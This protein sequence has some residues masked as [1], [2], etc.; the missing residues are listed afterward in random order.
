MSLTLERFN[1]IRQLGASNIASSPMSQFRTLT[2]NQGNEQPIDGMAAAPISGFTSQT[3]R[4][5]LSPEQLRSQQLQA[6]RKAGNEP[7]ARALERQEQMQSGGSIRDIF[8]RAGMQMDTYNIEQDILDAGGIFGDTE[9]AK[10]LT[11]IRDRV[12]QIQSDTLKDDTSGVFGDVAGSV[13][14][15]VQTVKDSILPTIGGAVVG[16]LVGGPA[17]A[18]LGAKIAFGGSSLLNWA[19]QGGG[20]IYADNIKDGIAPE[21]ARIVALAGG[22]I[23]GGIE[24]IFSVVSRFQPAL[25]QPIRNYLTKNL[26]SSILKAVSR[27]GFNVAGEVTEEGLQ[28]GVM[29]VAYNVAA[30]MQEN[31]AANGSPLTPFASA[32]IMGSMLE[33]MKESVLPIMILG[34]V[35]G[36]VDLQRARNTNTRIKDL[37]SQYKKIIPA[38]NDQEFQRI[39]EQAA[40]ERMNIP[41]A[42]RPMTVD[43]YINKLNQNMSQVRQQELINARAEAQKATEQIAIKQEGYRSAYR[44]FIDNPNASSQDVIN[45][46]DAAAASMDVKPKL[47]E[48]GSVNT[49]AWRVA[50]E[51]V[52]GEDT[53][54]VD[55]VKARVLSEI[56]DAYNQRLDQEAQ[57]INPAKAEEIKKNKALQ[58]I[59]R[60]EVIQDYNNR[61][62]G[63]AIIKEKDLIQQLKAP[64]TK[65]QLIEQIRSQYETEEG[66]AAP[67]ATPQAAPQAQGQVTPPQEPPEAGGAA[68]PVTPP[69]TPIE[70]TRVTR[71]EQQ[72]DGTEAEVVYEKVTAKSGTQGWRKIDAQTGARVGPFLTSGKKV[73]ELEILAR[74]QELPKPPPPPPPAPPMTQEQAG[75]ITEDL[76]QRQAAEQ[77]PTGVTDRLGATAQQELN[78]LNRRE[79][80]LRKVNLDDMTDAQMQELE[81]IEARKEEILGPATATVEERRILEEMGREPEE[82]KPPEKPESEFERIAREARERKIAEGEGKAAVRKVEE[83]RKREQELKAQAR[84]DNEERRNSLIERMRDPTN[85]LELRDVLPVEE[86]QLIVQGTLKKTDKKT[87]REYDEFVGEYIYTTKNGRTAWY[88]YDSTKN[89]DVPLG[90]KLGGEATDP[91]LIASLEARKTE[92]QSADLAGRRVEVSLKEVADKLG[93]SENKAKALLSAAGYSVGRNIKGVGR[94]VHK[95]GSL[96]QGKAA[97]NRA[98]IEAAQPEVN[99]VES[100]T[101]SITRA[102]NQAPTEA[103]SA[104]DDEMNAIAD[105]LRNPTITKERRAELTARGKELL[106]IRRNQGGREVGGRGQTEDADDFEAQQ[107]RYQTASVTNNQPATR[108]NVGAWV[109]GVAQKIV[110]SRWTEDRTSSDTIGHLRIGTKSIRFVIGDAGMTPEGQRAAGYVQ[111][112]TVG[113]YTIVIDKNTGTMSTPRHELGHILFDS[114]TDG[115]KGALNTALGYDIST[116]GGQERFV[117]ENLESDAARNALADRI[118]GLGV[119]QRSIVVRAINAVI[120]GLNAM[121]GTNIA[122]LGRGAAISS[123]TAQQLSDGLRD[124]SLIL[125]NQQPDV[126]RTESWNKTLKDNN[127]EAGLTQREMQ[128]NLPEQRE[129]K[130]G[131]TP[132]QVEES[133]PFKAWSN[134]LPIINAGEKPP[135]V[136]G[137]IVKAFH[138][139]SENFDTFKKGEFGFHFGT[140]NQATDRVELLKVYKDDPPGLDFGTPKTY[141]EENSNMMPVYVKINKPLRL[142]DRGTWGS[143]F[144]AQELIRVGLADESLLKLADELPITAEAR[145]REILENNG[146]DGI[147]Y[148]NRHEGLAKSVKDL[149]GKTSDEDLI[150][151]RPEARDSYMVWNP[152]HIKSYTG[153]S[154]QFSTDNPDIRYQATQPNETIPYSQFESKYKDGN[155]W[156]G[157]GKEFIAFHRAR[158]DKGQTAIESYDKWVQTGALKATLEA[159]SL[160]QSAAREWA[161]KLPQKRNEYSFMSGIKDK[162]RFYMGQYGMSIRTLSRSISKEQGDLVDQNIQTEVVQTFKMRAEEMVDMAMANID[163]FNTDKERTD[164]VKETGKFIERWK[165]QPDIT[166]DLN[167]VLESP[168][169][170]TYGELYQVLRYMLN[171]TGI[172]GVINGL[173]VRD[174]DRIR[175]FRTKR[176]LDTPANIAALKEWAQ[177]EI[178]KNP[179]YAKLSEAQ[180]KIGDMLFPEINAVYKRLFPES[181][182][183]TKDGLKKEEFYTAIHRDVNPNVSAKNR[184]R[185][186]AILRDMSSLKKREEYSK[187]GLLIMDGL[188][189]LYSSINKSANFIGNAEFTTNY[190]RMLAQSV[191]RDGETTYEPTSYGRKILEVRGQQFFDNLIESI[192]QVE[193]SAY[194]LN[195]VSEKFVNSLMRNIARGAL[196][197][198][199]TIAMQGMALFIPLMRYNSD[200]VMS[201]YMS[202]SRGVSKDF[203]MEMARNSRHGGSIVH[204]LA[205]R[206]PIEEAQKATYRGKISRFNK[207]MDRV[208]R[209][210]YAGMRKADQLTVFAHGRIAWESVQR[211]MPSAT[212]QEK[213]DEFVK[214]WNDLLQ[215]QST[216][217]ASMKVLAHNRG[218]LGAVLNM[219][220]STINAQYLKIAES[221]MKAKQSGS[222]QDIREFYSRTGM[223]LLSMTLYA[224]GVRMGAEALRDMFADMFGD[225]EDKKKIKETREYENTNRYR[226]V[227]KE[228]I[229]NIAAQAPITTVGSS[230]VDLLT[231]YTLLDRR[232]RERYASQ[233]VANRSHPL[234]SAI[235]SG[236]KS[237]EAMQ[238]LNDA[239]QAYEENPTEQNKQRVNRA[240][241]NLYKS[242]FDFL[243]YTP[244]STPIPIW[245]NFL[246]IDKALFNLEQ[247]L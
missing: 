78:E 144:M 198:P 54:V 27:Y 38:A 12:L 33:A 138:G 40:Q 166:T 203:L 146:Y 34:G 85:D 193:G 222:Q 152:T 111:R 101:K 92:Q 159:T 132:K 41:S 32:E 49:P 174:G 59:V 116:L 137:F 17:G 71:M 226:I 235:A 185:L 90:D 158:K 82:P 6:E 61:I 213:A 151:E 68:A 234:A 91:D 98:E 97:A 5:M 134:N 199:T 200:I 22:L 121:L 182:W 207:F 107:D 183:P 15:L 192:D 231:E 240:M 99:V 246:S 156:K 123:V 150:Q 236:A 212:E 218:G 247:K 112:N 196:T 16:G 24:H 65:E 102:E 105:E 209:I 89:E 230:L 180:N 145:I 9:K 170:F 96:D 229:G 211:E 164:A 110:G 194:N 232:D 47:N 204:R 93:V 2:L 176:G 201:G 117:R 126:Q 172:R 86:Q 135:R 20:S 13:G 8:T 141:F 53:V 14:G 10:K 208:D 3:M 69:V 81:A 43:L 219:F 242:G 245:S 70:P 87:G 72:P 100:A 214:R 221:Y 184:N 118:A 120:R 225:D 202:G 103:A 160:E 75:A 84:S 139:T 95:A 147:V 142:R 11:A 130:V 31:M 94:M 167:G 115:Q 64:L 220:R 108:Q 45:A 57:Q 51:S 4:E 73:D 153:N 157:L 169:D 149:S 171:D 244:A 223:A 119:E 217:D 243:R 35:G 140:I 215:Y 216:G 161:G 124:F 163:R 187:K 205:H 21:N 206:L 178:A 37:E 113:E 46:L 195:D 128:S 179:D 76:A 104:V 42:Q 228:V 133:A 7:V 177:G 30:D 44:G 227:A 241:R 188:D 48:D 62:G 55:D 83:K 66:E 168:Q 39:Y 67:E 19:R 129:L 58:K 189:E 29:K 109:R 77:A 23:Y 114:L 190:R 56:V 155:S 63:K 148:L 197:G 122:E 60:Q 131:L 127:L 74:G 79:R 125:R 36:A 233:T 25:A 162:F 88:K 181:E 1:Q 237:L 28:E 224:T 239:N 50:A 238:R 80:E 210:G 191:E 18:A 175:T 186:V 173:T 136:G 26:S 154:G 143:R 165:T 52:F 106:D